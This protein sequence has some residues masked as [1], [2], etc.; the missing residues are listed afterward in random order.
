MIKLTR[1]TIENKSIKGYGNDIEGKEWE[2]LNIP[3]SPTVY[4][5]NAITISS[6]ALTDIV[7]LLNNSIKQNK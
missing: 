6:E 7:T 3:F 4:G 2:Y 5:L 1:V